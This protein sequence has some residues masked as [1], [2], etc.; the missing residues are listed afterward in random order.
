MCTSKGKDLVKIGN[1]PDMNMIK[2]SNHEESMNAGYWK[3]V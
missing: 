3:D 2:T 1:H